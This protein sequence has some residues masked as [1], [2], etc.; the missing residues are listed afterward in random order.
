[1]RD[2]TVNPHNQH[3]V[4]ATVGLASDFGFQTIAEGVE[5]AETLDAA[6]GLRV[7]FAQGYLLGRPGAGQARRG[8]VHDIALGS[9]RLGRQSPCYS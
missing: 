9:G 2:L 7:D 5:D 3:L 8:R 4:R 1:M 6:E